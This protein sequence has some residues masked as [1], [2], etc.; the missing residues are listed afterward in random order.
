MK[1]KK[2]KKSSK[3]VP[4]K[5]R[6]SLKG[7]GDDQKEFIE[8]KVKE[9]KTLKEVEVFYNREDTVSSYAMKIAKKMRL[10]ES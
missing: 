5:K 2:A 6:I 1:T 3:E 10:P 8:S 7:L 4:K 9:F